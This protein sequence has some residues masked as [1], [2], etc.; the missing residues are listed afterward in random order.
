MRR[1]KVIVDASEI[2]FVRYFAGRPRRIAMLQREMERVEVAQKLYDLR[3]KH[4]LT[5][6]QLAKLA[7]MKPSAISR[8]EDA[9]YRGHSFQTLCRIATVLNERVEINFVPVSKRFRAA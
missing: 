3:A 2:L 6:A 5:Q 7:G 8:L 1:K 4:K 9:D